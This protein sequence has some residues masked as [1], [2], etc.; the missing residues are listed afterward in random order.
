MR[1]VLFFNLECNIQVAVF[2]IPFYMIYIGRKIVF[3]FFF[4]ATIHIKIKKFFSVSTFVGSAWSLVF[5][6]PILILEKE[7]VFSLLNVQC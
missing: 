4:T 1:C 7:P 6:I 2:C 3:L 5:F